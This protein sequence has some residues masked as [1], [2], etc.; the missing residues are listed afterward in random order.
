MLFSLQSMMLAGW[1]TAELAIFVPAFFV[2]LYSLEWGRQKSLQWL[3]AYCL[4]FF[5]DVLIFDPLKVFNGHVT[6]KILVQR[7]VIFSIKTP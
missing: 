1:I 2:I 6:V 4:S 3:A 5:Q 7:T